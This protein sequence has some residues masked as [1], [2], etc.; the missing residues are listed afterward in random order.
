MAKARRRRK[1]TRVIQPRLVSQACL[2]TFFSTGIPRNRPE[3]RPY[4][5]TVTDTVH[6]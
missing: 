2:L 3:Q 1:T 5:E 4:V 6:R